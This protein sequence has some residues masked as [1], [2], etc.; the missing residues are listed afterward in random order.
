M[1]I[2]IC[3][4]IFEMYK[5]TY[6]II[7]SLSHT[8]VCVSEET[9]KLVYKIKGNQTDEQTHKRQRRLANTNQESLDRNPKIKQGKPLETSLLLITRFVV[10]IKRLIIGQSQLRWFSNIEYWLAQRQ[11]RFFHWVST[12]M[13]AAHWPRRRPIAVL[14][15][16]SQRHSRVL[17]SRKGVCACLLLVLFCVCLFSLLFLECYAT[18]VFFFVGK[19]FFLF[20]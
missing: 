20:F 4:N 1:C 6:K 18:F 12:G 2:C 7:I 16:I 19:I 14:V 11:H 15:R 9:N 8:Q 13:R 3:I 5:H 17:L 10:D